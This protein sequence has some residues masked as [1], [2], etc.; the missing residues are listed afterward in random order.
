MINNLYQ[1]LNISYVGDKKVEKINGK[2][3]SIII[4]ST[5]DQN[6]KENKNMIKIDLCKCEDILK[7]KYNILKDDSLY[8]L[9]IINK[10]NNM[11]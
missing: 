8:I 3:I 4:E 7:N 5:K 6:I 2:N 10:P 11:K 1:Q 9:K